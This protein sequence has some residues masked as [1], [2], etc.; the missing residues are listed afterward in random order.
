MTFRRGRCP[1]VR[2][3]NAGG[4]KVSDRTLARARAGDELAF[5]ELTGPCRREP[6][7]HWYRIPGSVQDAGDML[8]ETL[9]AAWRVLTG[10]VGRR[11]S[12]RSW[13]Y[14]IATNR[15]LN[16]LGDSERRP[17]LRRDV[18]VQPPFQPPEPTGRG[19][20]LRLE[21]YP[22]ALPDDPAEPAPGPEA[23]YE[24]RE[25]IALAFVAAVQHLPP[26]QRAVLLLRDALGFRTAEVAEIL[27]VSEAA[28]ASLLQR[29][30]QT[31]EAW[32]P[33]ASR[34]R[35]PLPRSAQE[36]RLVEAFTAAYLSDDVDGLVRLLADDALLTM[37]PAILEYQGRDAI[38]AFLRDGA[39][40]RGSRTCKLIPTSANGQPA[41]GCYLRE[42]AAPVFHA[43]GL[44]VL[45]LAGDQIC[46]IT[47]F[48]DNSLL[49]RF[50]F[51]RTLRDD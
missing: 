4:D 16:A 1:N 30:R 22:D 8:Q 19:E 35:P 21:P 34:E 28:V 46:A 51:P 43:H 45:T 14:R 32:L 42:P 47:W 13:L 17:G 25:S 3:E 49:A 2:G 15:C 33:G 38:T 20:P 9:L 7:L 36:R 12:M 39:R 44:I 18:P 37:P 27:E 50:G 48:V 10:F 26:R 23:R 5:R 6:Q 40:W 31:L 11:V 41:F 29:A 24:A